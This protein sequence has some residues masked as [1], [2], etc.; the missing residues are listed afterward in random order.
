MSDLQEPLSK[1]GERSE[2]E[3]H[4]QRL[5]DLSLDLMCVADFEGYF[6]RINPAFQRTLGYEPSELLTRQF[7]EFVHPD[8]RESTVREVESLSRGALTVDFENR[9]LTRDGE[10]LWLAW[11]SAP[12]VETGLIYAVARDI[13]RQKADRELLAR[14]AEELA[15]SN[16]D[17]EEFAYVASHDLRAPLRSIVNLAKFIEE[18]LGDAIPER[19]RGH[20]EQLRRRALRMKALT[21]DLLIYSQAGRERDEV[22]EVDTSALVRDVAFLLD[23][24]DG[25]V[26]DVDGSMPVF[27][28]VRGPLEQVLRNLIGNAIKHHDR[29]EGTILVSSRDLGDSWEFAVTD[30][31]PGIAEEDRKR[32][33]GVFQQVLRERLEGSGIGLS[34]VNRIVEAFGSRVELDAANGRGATFRFGWPKRIEECDADTVDR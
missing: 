14:Q 12:V 1:T 28:T 27:R 2:A 18:D 24:P 6:R 17:L 3:L 8:D 31:G 34:V 9:Y 11:R 22:V 5:F 20:L 25:M 13:T 16:A 29:D 26:V 30:D 7:I 33:F 21:D 23:P 4:L 19:T 10:Y 32:V 15:R